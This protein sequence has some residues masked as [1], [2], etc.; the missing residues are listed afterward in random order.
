MITLHAHEYKPSLCLS[1]HTCI[2]RNMCVCVRYTHIHTIMMSNLAAVISH[3][4]IFSFV[5]RLSTKL[6]HGSTYPWYTYIYHQWIYQGHLN[7]LMCTHNPYSHLM[8]TLHTHTHTHIRAHLITLMRM[9]NSHTVIHMHTIHTHIRVHN[10][11]L[12]VHRTSS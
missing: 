8:Q 3:T 7:T 9:H 1:P 10:C 4:K 2:H 5:H 12:I 6:A 11:T